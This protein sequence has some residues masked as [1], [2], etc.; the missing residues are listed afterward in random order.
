MSV[1]ISRPDWIQEPSDV[2]FSQPQEGL[3][4]TVGSN[5]QGT[6][7]VYEEGSGGCVLQTLKSSAFMVPRITGKDH[8]KKSSSPHLTEIIGPL[9]NNLVKNHRSHSSKPVVQVVF[10]R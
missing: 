10:E 3:R 9:V 5:Q 8:K 7:G 4:A 6:T 2:G 1:R